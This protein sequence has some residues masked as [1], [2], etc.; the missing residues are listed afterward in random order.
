MPYTAL[1][2]NKTLGGPADSKVSG[3]HREI[4]ISIM[5][6]RLQHSMRVPL[7]SYNRSHLNPMPAI[8]W[9]FVFGIH[10]SDETV[11]EEPN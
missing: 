8:N 9:E 5:N 3:Q 4:R 2:A 6:H 1:V 7:K 11:S 10:A